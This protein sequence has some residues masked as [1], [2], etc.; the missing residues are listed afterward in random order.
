MG[1][2]DGWMNKGWR[3]WVEE[4][5]HYSPQVWTGGREG[6]NRLHSDKAWPSGGPWLW[7]TMGLAAAATNERSMVLGTVGLPE[8]DTEQQ[9]KGWFKSRGKGGMHRMRRNNFYC[10]CYYFIHLIIIIMGLLRNTKPKEE[11][12]GTPSD[13]QRPMVWTPRGLR[14]QQPMDNGAKDYQKV[15]IIDLAW[16]TE[17]K[18]EWRKW[19]KTRPNRDKN[20]KKKERNN[21]KVLNEEGRK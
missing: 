2:D 12:S 18:K 7:T 13:R 1:W 17:I 21:W 4:A 8:R 20:Q 6:Q 16:L 19:K 9:G 11:T 10:Y 3:R 15:N 5:R 14:Q